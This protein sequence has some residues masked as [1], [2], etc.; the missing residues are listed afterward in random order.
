MHIYLLT[1]LAHFF[2][3]EARRLGIKIK[4]DLERG[5]PLNKD[6]TLEA[7]HP[8]IR[9]SGSKPHPLSDFG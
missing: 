6:D 8:V 9:T 3:D 1:D 7:H 5:H 4:T 2:H